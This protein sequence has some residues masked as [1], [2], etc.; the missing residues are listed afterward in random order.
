MKPNKGKLKYTGSCTDLKINYGRGYYLTV[1]LPS[2]CSTYQFQRIESF[3]KSKLDCKISK[4]FE[5]EVEFVI[6]KSE[7]HKFEHFFQVC[8]SK[9]QSQIA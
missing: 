2:S 6:P 1:S 3:V 7:N 5:Q 4:I 9:L 8:Q